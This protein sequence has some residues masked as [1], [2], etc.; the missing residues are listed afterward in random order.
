M[1]F[2]IRSI[3][4]FP[5]F[6]FF[7]SHNRLP[8]FTAGSLVKV[9]LSKVGC[10]TFQLG[11]HSPQS[12]QRLRYCLG[13]S[14]AFQTLHSGVAKVNHVTSDGGLRKPQYFGN[15][16]VFRPRQTGIALA[17]FVGFQNWLQSDSSRSNT[18]EF[19]LSEVGSYQRS[20]EVAL[21]RSHL[22]PPP[23]SKSPILSIAG[24]NRWTLTLKAKAKL[25]STKGF[26]GDMIASLSTE[27]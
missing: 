4:A 13:C 18:S 16:D 26:R 6:T 17:A 10:L 9:S 19:V 21:I 3:R 7:Q 11:K 24:T 15:V 25:H 22:Q 2:V 5:T 23:H 20:S 12:L 1:N 27:K 14:T 8:T